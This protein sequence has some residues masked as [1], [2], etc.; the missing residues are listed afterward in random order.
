[1][2]DLRKIPSGE[3]SGEFSQSYHRLCGLSLESAGDLLYLSSPSHREACPQASFWGRGELFMAGETM[4]P[5]L[6]KMST[7]AEYFYSWD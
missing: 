7:R 1:M 3:G 4:S 6:C 2:A 5:L